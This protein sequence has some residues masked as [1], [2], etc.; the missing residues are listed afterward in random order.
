M[1]EQNFSHLPL[2]E[3]QLLVG[4][5]L[6]ATHGGTRL[7]LIHMQNLQHKHKSFTEAQCSTGKTFWLR[8]VPQ[9][10]VFECVLKGGHPGSRWFYV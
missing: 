1:Y 7:S 6:P 8:K 3:R 2:V 10:D 5:T 9:E 4:H